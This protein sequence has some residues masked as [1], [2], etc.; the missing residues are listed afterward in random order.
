MCSSHFLQG[1][2]FWSRA[3]KV[4]NF[5][6]ENIVPGDYNLYAWIPGIFGDYKYSTIITITPGT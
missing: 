2:Q 3:D 1:Y 6:I 5:T 4:G